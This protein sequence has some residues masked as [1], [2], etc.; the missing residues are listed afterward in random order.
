MRL[1]YRADI[2]GIR[3][4]AVLAVIFY[5]AD[6]KV[7]SGG[8]VG[9]DIFFVISGYLI[10]TI[11]FREIN[12]NEFSLA[13][14]Y[15]RRIRRIFPALFTV[16]LF[17]VFVSYLFF[18]TN[19]FYD[20]GKTLVSATI[21]GSNILFWT[22]SG[23][24]EGPA[25][26]KPLLHT[27]SLAVE[28]Q[29]YIFFPLLLMFLARYL[30]PRLKLTL[31][32]LTL[33]SFLLN[34]YSLH[35][36][37]SAAFYLAHMRVWELLIGSL[38]AIKIIPKTFNSGILNSLSLLGLVMLGAP[39]FLYTNETS[40]P[41]GA[42][43]IPTLG[44]ALLIF[45]N[46]E[47]KTLAGR[48]LSLRPLVFIGQISYSL[49]LWHWPAI[50][51]A[52]YY[53]IIELKALEMAAVLL[54]VF[55]LS[56]LSWHFIEKP[57]RQKSFIKS[58]K[59]FAPA[60]I[61]M[62][63][64]I[65]IGSFIYFSGGFPGRFA[66]KQAGVIPKTDVEWQRWSKCGLDVDEPP[67]QL[68]LCAIGENTNTPT[69]LLWGDSH[70]RA[71]A[72]SIQISASQAGAAGVM[73]YTSGCSPLRGVDR[74]G[75]HSCSDFNEVMLNYVR[76]HPNLD[77]V[78]LASRWALSAEGTR[79]KNEEGKRVILVNTSTGPTQTDTN[80]SLFQFGLDQTVLSLLKM[81]RKVV[82]I[83]EVPEIGYDVPS[84][85]SIAERTGR[86]INKII[87]PSLNEYRARNA[88]VSATIESIASNDAVQI[89]DPSKVL[90]MNQTCLVATD[91]QALYRDDDHLSSYGAQYISSIFDPI[92]ENF[93]DK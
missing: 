58:S 89:V 11:I 74:Q 31:S 61:A 14:F 90:C 3:G 24:F 19:E 26:I 5:H 42:A 16:L 57:F 27:W 87:A 80:A 81:G 93:R 77:T 75:R 73:V 84:A 6:I 37:A 79:Y 2:D 45:G 49:Y 30:R 25:A 56:I 85:F 32:G 36:D 43:L 28:E 54:A 67:S 35:Y 52:K 91:G 69:F 55:L 44:T 8:F 68:E 40:F 70:V 60:G 78:I 22:Q 10:T 88:I 83:T 86:D 65:A 72:T 53:A 48:I 39:F 59:I 9:V 50:V 33:A 41:G 12:E 76:D 18:D 71:L 66:T 46:I 13:Q 20:F 34:V 63:L 7:F 38:L 4:I 62:A 17:T 23:Y 21:F 29:Y 64:T 1:N 47:S 82:I 51:F 15:E 92:F